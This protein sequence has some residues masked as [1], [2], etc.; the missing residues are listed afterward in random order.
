MNR[1]SRVVRRR[2]PV[3][4][5]MDRRFW[6]IAVSVVY[7]GLA[8]VYTFRWAPV[9]RHIPSVWL[10]PG[11]MLSTYGT[12]IEFAQG[13]FANVYQPGRGFLSYPGFLLALLPLAVFNNSFSG[14]WINFKVHGH[15][16]AHPQVFLAPHL[17]SGFWY[18]GNFGPKRQ[19]WHRT[20][21]T[22]GSLSLPDHLRP[23]LLV[24]GTVRLRRSG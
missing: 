2:R 24:R 9:V 3:V 22:A 6:P 14:S 23:R 13:H 10:A 11:D 21:N 16:V 19:S 4:E 15:V 20:G 18:Q 12:A 5:R 1:P 8:L 17:P 7:V